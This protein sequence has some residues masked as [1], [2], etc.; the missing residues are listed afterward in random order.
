MHRPSLTSLE[1]KRE[2]VKRRGRE[3]EGRLGRREAKE[4]KSH[5]YWLLS[6]PNVCGTQIF[7]QI[8][9]TS[10]KLEE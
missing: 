7:P 3:H 4:G 1:G 9:Y 2:G 5:A 8:E 10:S 6:L